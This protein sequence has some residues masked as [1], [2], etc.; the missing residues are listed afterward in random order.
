[1]PPQ[2]R[3]AFGRFEV[4]QEIP[5]RNIIWSSEGVGGSGKTHFGLTAPEPIA[6]MLF[7]P[8]GLKGLMAQEQFKVRDIRVIDYTKTYNIAKLKELQDRAKA[9]Q[10]AVAQFEEDWQIAIGGAFRTILW[11]KEDHVW[12]MQ[13]YA[14]NENFQ[15]EPKTYYELNM[16]YKGKFSEAETAG[17]NFGVIRG[18]KEA[19]G[20]TGV[21][22]QTGK[23]TYG[24]TGTLVPRGQKEVTELVQVNLS[25]RW[26]EESRGFR[27]TILDKCRLGN[28]LELMGQEYASLDFLT[29]AML[30]YPESTPD[31]WGL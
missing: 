21:N 7:D 26:D 28:A 11:D 1:M 5:A 17:V 15:A 6:V 4:A 24:G 18:M 3:P 13:R 12:E 9:A 16:D 19:W 29:L 30:L 14:N 10:D 27:T 31:D 2:I 8:A 23:P 20:K 22:R 25:H